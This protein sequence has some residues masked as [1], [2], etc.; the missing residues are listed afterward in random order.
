MGGIMRN[1]LLA[2]AAV[3]GL[4][5]HALAWGSEG[6]EVVAQIGETSLSPNTRSQVK[7]LL[8]TQASSLADVANWADQVRPSRPETAPWHY[9]DIPVESSGYDAQRDCRN[10]D[11]VVAQITLKVMQIGDLSLLPAVRLEALKWVVHLVGDVHQPLHCADNGDRG[12]NEIAVTFEGHRKKLHSI[13]DT[14]I[15][16]AAADD[17]GDYA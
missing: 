14:G 8:G 4:S 1:L 16:D 2:F 11:C 3:V 13:W 7:E 10:D 12:G 6:H 9:V 15:I 17:R 5:S